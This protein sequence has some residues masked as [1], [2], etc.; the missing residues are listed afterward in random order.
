[1]PESA[2]QERGR[3]ACRRPC[4]GPG[5]CGASV[6]RTDSV[7]SVLPFLPCPASA[8]QKFD[9]ILLLFWDRP[10]P[11]KGN[12]YQRHGSRC[13]SRRMSRLHPTFP[14]AEGLGKPWAYTPCTVCRSAHGGKTTVE[15]SD[16]GQDSG[17]VKK[18]HDM[19]AA[20][21]QR[22][23]HHGHAQSRAKVGICPFHKND[24]DTDGTSE[25]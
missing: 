3:A 8:E 6:G 18:D 15:D 24:S 21:G 2:V 5:C 11:T 22:C 7:P 10:R 19:D 1:M 25:R 20:F 23:L 9:A 16:S 4:G 17:R 12:W 14:A 13:A